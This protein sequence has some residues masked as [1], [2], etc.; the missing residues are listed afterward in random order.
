[1]SYKGSICYAKTINFDFGLQQR[2]M[3][4]M[5]LLAERGWKV[6]FINPEDENK[7]PCKVRERFGNLEVYNN[8]KIF[9]ERV[10]KVDI[11]FSSWAI[12][13]V[14]LDE[15]DSQIVV[16]DSLDNFKEWEDDE[17]IMIKK[18][19]IVFTT[20]EPLYKI[21]TKEHTNV[22]MCRNGCFSELGNKTYDIPDDLKKIK[23]LGKPILL[24]SGAVAPWVDVDIMKKIA[25]KYSLV[26]V[27]KPWDRKIPKNIH[28]LG[29]KTYDKLQAYYAHCDIGLLPF[30]KSHQAAYYSNPIKCYEY[31]T[32]GKQTVAYDIPEACIYKD[33]VLTSRKEKDFMKNIEVALL[34]VNNQ[35]II[36][37]CK[38]M[39]SENNWNNRV[40][41]IE[42]NI[43]KMMKERNI[44][45]CQ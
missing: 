36:N 41:I 31:A 24:F 39:A 18:S 44:L 1:M 17:P 27:G 20:S 43:M 16:Y 23:D 37:K 35:D 26:V 32:H 13:H 9:K 12:R 33:V 21:R 29:C 14:D 8:W 11:Y 6:Y 25:D 30:L 15:I 45:P 3:H 22:T 4:V 38:K 42:E 19:D 2:P 5:R 28:Y 7:N 10:P 34:N 40:D